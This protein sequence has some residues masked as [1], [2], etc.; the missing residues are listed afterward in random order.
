MLRSGFYAEIKKSR[1]WA[2]EGFR[3]L[4]AGANQERVEQL[5]ANFAD[6]LNTKLP[7]AIRAKSR[8]ADY[9]TSPYV[10]M[11]T[12]GVLNLQDPVALAR[13][14]INLKMYMGLE[15]SFGKSIES[16]VMGRYPIDA[17]KRI[18]AWE[19]PEEKRIEFDALIGLSN[20]E[21]SRK[22]SSSVWREID[23]SCVYGDRRHLLTIKSGTATINDSQVS[24]MKDSIRDNHN[25][26]LDASR[27]RYNVSGID[28]VVGLTYGTDR[29][30]NNKEN[31]I[32]NKLLDHGFSERDR[33][34]HPGVLTNADGSIRIY[35]RIGVDYWSYVG[36]PESPDESQF[37]FLEVL[38][39][40]AHALRVTR[41]HGDI[42]AALNE[43][44]EALG[45][46][47]KGLVVPTATLPEWI[48]SSF[49]PT[50]LTWLMASMTAF[51]DPD[52]IEARRLAEVSVE[53]MQFDE[54]LDD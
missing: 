46:A 15:T 2:R 20:E 7:V 19:E 27:E 39:A 25:K 28:V 53:Q 54:N 51:F 52:S 5:G 36:N 26:W 35:R 11:T 17:S 16:V 49:E 4:L 9:R 48:R 22:R 33:A 41:T 34:S 1:P 14:L 37:V 32:L 8:L 6:Y 24:A 21:K 44:L 40:L 42:E 45:D 30:T 18:T 23:K 43:R 12:A 3:Q 10:L 31:Q 50:E 47:I 29:T 13:F 38:L